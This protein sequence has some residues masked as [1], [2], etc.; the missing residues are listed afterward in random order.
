[1]RVRTTNK[2]VRSRKIF[3]A[4]PLILSAFTHL[5][6][7]VGF[8]S[9]YVDE[10]HYMRRAVQII[11]GAGHQEIASSLNEFRAYDHPY[12]GQIFLA[13][14]LKT[15]G[16]PFSLGPLDVSSTSIE[17][18]YLAPR[19]LMGLLAIIDTLLVYKIAE[20][21]YNSNVA[22]IAS[23]LF[24]VMPMTW[25]L[26]RI[27]LDSM[28]LPFLLASVLFAVY[29][30]SPK[31]A[32]DRGKKGNPDSSLVIIS[33]IFLGLAILTKI[34]SITA[35][36]LIV[37]LILTSDNNRKLRSL[38]IWIVPVV[39]IPAIWP[40]YAAIYGQ[41]GEWW[42]GVSW[43]TNRISRALFEPQESLYE[44][45]PVLVGLGI[46]GIIYGAIKR[47]LFFVIWFL[48]Y[49]IL[50]VLIGYSQYIH[51]VVM[52]PVFCVAAA[53]LIES[54]SSRLRRLDKLQSIDSNSR[55]RKLT[56]FLDSEQPQQARLYRNIKNR[57]IIFR[58]I[59]SRAALFI[60]SAIAIFGLINTT[61]LLSAD[62]NSS[63]FT[64]YASFIRHLPET[65]DD[66][67][68]EENT[69]EVIGPRRWGAYL[70]WLPKYVFNK[71]LE[72]HD[73]KDAGSNLESNLIIIREGRPSTLYE[74]LDMVPTF[75]GNVKNI[76]RQYNFQVYPYTNMKYNQIPSIEM[77]S[78]Y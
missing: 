12:F 52:L 70:F 20:R 4:L 6:N 28:L 38:A 37:Y 42:E 69:V 10:G 50:L 17:M 11:E 34:P 61:I 46:T 32:L 21:R 62:V 14:M 7:P 31:K 2:I 30:N 22:F 67:E 18:L 65:A 29:Y 5:W 55:Y 68:E 63:F 74:D 48:P 56:D 49:I 26:R 77:R 54:I 57:N 44:I 36:P 45:D 35:A 51:L 41:L 27:L 8:P 39:L 78:S 25:L 53:N 66:E 64:G 24:A 15:I 59:F 71:D 58:F 72:F 9:I 19:I 16:Y 23:I 13:L 3:L 60:T 33:G 40:A 73:F 75:L 1:V 76:A 47:D 43:Q